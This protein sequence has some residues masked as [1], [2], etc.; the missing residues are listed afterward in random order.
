[1][2]RETYAALQAK[3]EK[4]ITKLQ[5]KA[6]ALQ[7]KRRKPVIAS[8]ITSMREYNITPEEIAAAFNGAAKAPRAASRKAA[9]PA[10][11]RQVAPK[12][13]HPDTGETWSGRGKAPRWLTAEEAEG[14]QRDSFLIKE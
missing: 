5:K 12:Y 4:E 7:S 9:A 2:P 14:K 11:K 10:A 3:I 8:I 1:M 13:R 6:E